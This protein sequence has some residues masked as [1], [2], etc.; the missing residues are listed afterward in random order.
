MWI[1]LYFE[2]KRAIEYYQAFGIC[3]VTFFLIMRASILITSLSAYVVALA[4]IVPKA[5][6]P[7][8]VAGGSFASPAVAVKPKFRYW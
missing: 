2:Y 7:G 8:G 4:A 5:E 1:N 3:L 6:A